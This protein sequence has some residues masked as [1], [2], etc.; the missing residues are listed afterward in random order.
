VCALQIDEDD[1]SAL[2]RLKAPYLAGEAEGARAVGGGHAQDSARGEGFG[3]VDYLLKQRGGAHL[4][5][6]VEAVVARR[7]VGPERDGDAA[8]E[9]LDDR[10]YP[11][12]ELKVRGRAVCDVRSRPRQQFLL[13]PVNVDAVREHDVRPRQAD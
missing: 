4:R 12:R 10:G 11:R 8:P 9:H 6:H 1:V 5:E 3:A 7:A 2:A 13:T